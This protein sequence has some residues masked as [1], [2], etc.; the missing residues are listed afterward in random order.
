MKRGQIVLETL[1]AHRSGKAFGRAN[2]RVDTV[3][4]GPGVGHG[5]TLHFFTPGE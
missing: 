3:R 5:L 1:A 4:T 2:G